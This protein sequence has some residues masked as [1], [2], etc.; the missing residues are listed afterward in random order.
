M[1][2]TFVVN[3]NIIKINLDN[4]LAFKKPNMCDFGID[5]VN[6]LRTINRD[7]LKTGIDAIEHK[8][9]KYLR[10]L[11]KELISRLPTNLNHFKELKL[12]SPQCVLSQCNRPEFNNLPFINIFIQK[13]NLHLCETQWK[14]LHLVDWIAVCGDKKCMEN[15]YVFW[16]KVLDYKDA[17]DNP[18][19]TEFATYAL[20]CLSLPTSNAVVERAFSVMNSIK[21]KFRNKMQHKMLESI[22]R[23]R[24][25]LYANDICCNSF[26]P[27]DEMLKRFTSKDVYQLDISN[28][29][30]N[31]I[32]IIDI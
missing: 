3:F 6:A 25:F 22:M 8:A 4:D 12:L 30:V 9:E 31:V 32:E 26:Q 18:V 29:D 16:P 17:G 13:E 27:N 14:K 2:N 28:G 11:L 23:L 10:S 15:S 21:T 20:C 7:N 24:L 19:F 1:T 5:Y